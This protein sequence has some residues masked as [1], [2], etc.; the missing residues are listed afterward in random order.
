MVD[1]STNVFVLVDNVGGARMKAHYSCVC[2]IQEV[3]SGEYDMT[4]NWCPETFSF[5]EF[6]GAGNMLSHWVLKNPVTQINGYVG[7][8]DFKDY[9]FQH[10][11][12]SCTP[13]L[14]WMLSSLMQ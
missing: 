12:N 1:F 2:G 7:I 11:S 6:V 13:R 14:M 10:F 5:K 3:G 8:W 9:S 4:A